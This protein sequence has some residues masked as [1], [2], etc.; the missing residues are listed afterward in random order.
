MWAVRYMGELC[1]GLG[2][3]PYVLH[4]HGYASMVAYTVRVAEW[5]IGCASSCFTAY[6]FDGSRV[7]TPGAGTVNQAV[8]PSGV[9]K[10]VAISMQ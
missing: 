9:G 10:L 4:R 1:M 2:L 7:Q 8:H 5:A 6:E 3:F